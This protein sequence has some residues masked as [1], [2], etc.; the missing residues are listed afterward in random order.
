MKS[1]ELGPPT[2]N[3]A[4]PVKPQSLFRRLCNKLKNRSAT[5]GKDISQIPKTL[6]PELFTE[7][8]AKDYLQREIV[9]LKEYSKS[10]PFRCGRWPYT[11]FDIENEINFCEKV[12][13]KEDPLKIIAVAKGI[14]NERRSNIRKFDPPT[15]PLAAA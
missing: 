4:N 12:L 14:L 9:S 13:E 7:S 15:W 3:Q 8:W 5:C 11:K 2:T 6:E 10:Y 1:K